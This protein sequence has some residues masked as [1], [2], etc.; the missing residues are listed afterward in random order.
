M[1]HDINISNKKKDIDIIEVYNLRI[2]SRSSRVLILFARMKNSLMIKMM[3]FLR[4][5][6]S[7]WSFGSE[8][9]SK[10]SLTIDWINMLS[11]HD[12]RKR[13]LAARELLSC[14]IRKI[15]EE[16]AENIKE[17]K[18]WNMKNKWWLLTINCLISSM[19][20]VN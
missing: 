6:S 3:N 7:E 18:R 10:F 19:N 13:R 12:Q 1:N 16:I 17:N 8:W 11:I 5:N 14:V 4:K 2:S 15:D 20:F 9:M